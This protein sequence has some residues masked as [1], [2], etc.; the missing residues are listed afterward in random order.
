MAYPGYLRE[1][2]RQ[3][4]TEKHLTIDE[5]AARLAL[6][7]TTVYYWVKDIPLGRERRWSAGQRRG[8]FAMRQKWRR[9]RDEAYADGLESFDRL[10]A[11]PTFRDFV[12]LYI[13]E[14]YKRGRN[15]VAL[16]NSD[17]QIIELAATWLRRLSDHQL[18][19][20]VHHHADQD[21]DALRAV[22]SSTAGVPSEAVRFYRKS[23]SG[24]LRTRVWRCAYGVASVEVYDTYLRARLAA[25]MDRLRA[26]WE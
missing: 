25:W 20:R 21:L 4:R 22:W 8:N 2:A 18:R 1:R 7:R 3:L 13:A 23:N 9:L 6:P 12:V 24:E 26:G 16:A 5:L 10:A 19:V 17:P 15:T 14:G 11:S